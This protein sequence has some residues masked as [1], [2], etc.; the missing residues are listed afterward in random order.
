LHS[1]QNFLLLQLYPSIAALK[2]AEASGVAGR[3][4]TYYKG[5]T[6]RL[7]WLFET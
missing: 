3:S 6:L 1:P 7:F 5:V 4:A 2:H